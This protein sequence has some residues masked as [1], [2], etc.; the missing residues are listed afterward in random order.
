[1]T[2]INDTTKFNVQFSEILHCYVERVSL[3][4]TTL[5]MRVSRSK[6]E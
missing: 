4:M 3:T 2:N 5:Y 6:R 1:M